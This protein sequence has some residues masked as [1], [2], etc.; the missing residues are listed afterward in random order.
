MPATS[1]V[2]RPIRPSPSA[3]TSRTIQRELPV[4]IL[5]FFILTPLPG[6]ADHKA[7][8]ERGEWMDPD[9]NRY[10][11]EHVTTH[12]PR[13]TTQE[14]TDIYRP[15]L[16]PVLQPA[17]RRDAVAACRSGR[18]GHEPFDRCDHGLLRQLSL[19]GSASASS[20]H[21]AAQGPC[22]AASRFA[23]RQPVAFLCSPRVGNAL[24]HGRAGPVRL[25]IERMWKAISRDPAAKT[26]SDASLVD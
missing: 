16:A 14:W 12:H 25:S 26:Y 9:L 21:L 8:R 24:V 5:E 19:R 4:D 10:D 6:S 7:L 1:S 23:P 2:S 20:R 3:A 11:V 18:G 17:A 15:R 22:L 13:M